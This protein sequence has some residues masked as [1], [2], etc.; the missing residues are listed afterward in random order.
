MASDMYKRL[1]SNRHEIRILEFDWTERVRYGMVKNESLIDIKPYTALS[2]CWG[3]IASDKILLLYFE[4]TTHG[5]RVPITDNLHSALLALWKRKGD[6]EPFIRL[7]IDAICINQDDLYER[8]QQVQMMRQIYSGAEEVVAW[9]GPIVESPFPAGSDYFLDTRQKFENVWQARKTFFNEEYWKRV[10]IIQEITVASRVTMLYGDHEFPWESLVVVLTSL[11][12]H[13]AQGRTE[14]K[15]EVGEIAASHILKFRE[16][17]MDSNKPITLYQAMTWTL[18]T[19]ATDPRDKIF[20]LLGLC[21]DGFRLVPI[22]N[23]RQSLESIISEMSRLMFSRSRSLDLM[24]LRG[25]GEIPEFSTLRSWV[26]NWPFLC[27]CRERIIL[28]ILTIIPKQ[29]APPRTYPIELLLTVSL[30]RV[31]RK[32]Y[33]ARENDSSFSNVCQL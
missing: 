8:S 9:V 1:D 14:H 5:R 21:H 24:C 32:Y 23:Y 18:H 19:K 33:C 3:D 22:P 15:I 13:L 4:H 26:P 31:I 6:G 7:W 29:W 12:E 10:W 16:H 25:T 11:L 2:Y 28:S 20:A 27:K 17:W 30:P